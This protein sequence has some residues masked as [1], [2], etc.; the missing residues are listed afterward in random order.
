MPSRRTVLGWSVASLSAGVSGC[1]GLTESYPPTGLLVVNADPEP[2]TV[3]VRVT[4]TGETTLYERE[5]TVA[6]DSNLERE[7]IV[8][9]GPIR[10]TA[11][12]GEKSGT[13][14][15][16]YFDFSGCRQARLVITLQYGDVHDIGKQDTCRPTEATYS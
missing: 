6:A 7:R 3:T 16:Q 13:A 9:T 11:Y 5:F 12:V 8:D 2:R 1:V 14:R 4:D 10:V 15:D